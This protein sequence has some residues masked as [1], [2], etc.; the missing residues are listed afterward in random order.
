MQ[1]QIET[2]FR[3]IAELIELDRECEE[4]EAEIEA[5]RDDIIAQLQGA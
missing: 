3:L 1:N 4:R 2:Y 5:I